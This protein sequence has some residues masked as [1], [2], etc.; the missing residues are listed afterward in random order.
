[1]SSIFYNIEADI[2]T[3]NSEGIYFSRARIIFHTKQSVYFFFFF[4]YKENSKE[5]NTYN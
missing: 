2:L 3:F 5:D 4:S 1:M